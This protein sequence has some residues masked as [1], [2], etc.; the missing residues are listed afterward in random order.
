MIRFEAE[1][2]LKTVLSSKKAIN[3]VVD[4]IHFNDEVMM[5]SDKRITLHKN[6]NIIMG[7]DTMEHRLT[8]E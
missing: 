3:N 6:D 7:K 1:I 5:L 8:Y 2:Y 4:G